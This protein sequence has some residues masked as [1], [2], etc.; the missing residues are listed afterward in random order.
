M[1][2]ICAGE[3][4]TIR[5]ERGG[6]LLSDSDGVSTAFAALSKSSRCFDDGE[7]AVPRATAAA[8]RDVPERCKRT[9]GVE[10][11]GIL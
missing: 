6:E 5:G 7:P 10:G 11:G 9:C 1:G 4:A 2:G 3:V 8:W